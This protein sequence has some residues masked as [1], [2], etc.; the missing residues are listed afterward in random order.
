MLRYLET[1][2][3][4]VAAPPGEGPPAGLI[5]FFWYFISQ[6][7]WLFAALF[8]VG[9]AAALVETA[10][11]YFIGRLVAILTSTPREELFAT[12]WPTFATM[13]GV[14]LVARPAILFV[15]RAISNHGI[16][17]PLNTLTRWQSHH[18]VIRQSLGFFQNDFAGRIANHVMQAGGGVRETALATMRS[19]L[20]ILF[21]GVAATG[22]MLAQ[23]WRLALPILVWVVLYVT[24]LTAMVPKLRD[25]SREASAK[26][27]AVTGKVVDGYTNIQTVKLFARTADEDR[28]IRDA[29]LEMNTAFLAQHRVNTLFTV[30]LNLLN[31]ALLAAVGTLAVVQWQAGRVEIGAV[32]MVLPLTI[33]LISMS[34]WVAAEIQGIFENV[35]VVQESMGSIARPITMRD[36]P[37][38]RPLAVTGGGITFDRV[39]F[40]YGRKDRPVIDALSL[41]IRPGEK[42]G[43][44]GRSGAGKSTLVNL[45][46]RFHDVEEGAIRI[47]GQD[48]REVTQES[49]RQAVS[50][51]TQDTSLLHR[52]IRDNI[53]YG[54]PDASEAELEAA[55][56]QAHADSFIPGLRDIA[57]RTGYDA[58][59]GER[60]VKLSGGQRQRIAIARVILKDAPIL[61]L[62]EA[63]AALDSEVEAA[64]QESLG[65]L[66]EGKTVLAI[67]HRLSTLKIMDRLV[68]ID[69]GRIVEEGSHDALIARRGLYAQLWARQSGGFLA[70]LTEAAE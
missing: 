18:H 25:R 50:V 51:V 69:G 15:Q 13:L 23:D 57:G 44:V 19:V 34:G 21:Y 64:I 33:Q 54:R 40:G 52:S 45:M 65:D 36:A 29:M 9:I 7:K 12:A 48:V 37:E 62:D 47:D 27:S 20:H 49:L 42:V 32:A 41:T 66:M 17:G 6:A 3:D 4:P 8:V 38:A 16:S 55:A 28:Y 56:R 24:L 1:R 68:V 30:L 10:I 26:R 39:T 14:V 61:V 11:P 2:V 67:A 43:L 5:A 59:V 63:T 60:G 35:G 22:L 70:D 58:H 46:L 31:A 53:L